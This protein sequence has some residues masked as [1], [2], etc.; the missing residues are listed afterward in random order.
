MDTF[1]KLG[2][3]QV[4]NP[5][6]VAGTQPFVIPGEVD[7][8]HIRSHAESAYFGADIQHRSNLRVVAGVLVGRIIL[9]VR[10]ASCCC[11]RGAIP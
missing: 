11:Q 3:L 1:G 8:S 2:Y 6:R 5:I 10:E 9:E 4:E 7:L